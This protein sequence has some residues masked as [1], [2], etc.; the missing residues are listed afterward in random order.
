MYPSPTIV[1][2]ASNPD[3]GSSS[4]APVSVTLPQ[5][6]PGATA[7][8]RL[9][10]QAT[11]GPTLADLQHVQQTGLASYVD[12]Q[13]AVPPTILPVWADAN[14][15]GYPSYCH[16]ND[17]MN[18]C[19]ARV[20]WQTA[21]L[22]P[23]QLRQRVTFALSEMW[24]TS[25]VELYGQ[26]FS[27][28]SNAISQNALG[29]WRQLMQDVTLTP[30][31][32]SYL[33]MVN[34]YSPSG[35][36]LANE[37]Y[38]RELM[39]LFSLGPNQLNLDGSMILDSSG[40]PIP[41]YN[42][43][44]V[45][46]FARAYTGWTFA[47]PDCSAPTSFYAYPEGSC[48][49]QAYT[50]A[51]DENTKTLLRGVVLSGGQTA[52]QDLSDALDNIFAD[53]S[54]PPFVCRQLILKLV[55]SNPTPQ[56]IAR[57]SSV[58]IDNGKG[59]R[60]D[61]SSVVRAILLDPEAR[62]GDDPLYAT[63]TGGHLKEPVL[64]IT[65]VLR[66]LG[67]PPIY[68]NYQDGY[69]VDDLAGA[70]GQR[71]HGAPTVFNF[72]SP[73]YQLPNTSV[74]APEFEIENSATIAARLNAADGII[75]SFGTSSATNAWTSLDRESLLLQLNLVFLDDRMTAQMHDVILNTMSGTTDPLTAMRIAVY[76][77]VTSPQYR[78]EQ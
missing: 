40:N 27:T 64:W 12:E 56:Y 42:D 74:F 49:M 78:V 45:Q 62:A 47:Q 19:A 77:V 44:Q 38:G 6:L 55:T 17:I 14:S 3:P 65:G 26:F 63:G 8:S 36:Q 18:T 7:A 30:A 43:A 57:V 34:S 39:Q 9:L 25:S 61:M 50:G 35:G 73:S 24:V 76:L 29:N 1:V 51:H 16:H 33:N 66:G 67:A 69:G 22:A 32:G 15:P 20:F 4:S 72:Y 10:E 52:Q 48:P 13:L 37:N 2:V 58:F 60:G 71:P 23:D 41:T 31:M 68:S 70:M 54:L 11:F 75:L 59:I 53:P 46:A 21:I 28:Y 5:P